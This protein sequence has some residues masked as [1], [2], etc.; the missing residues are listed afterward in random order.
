M[1]GGGGVDIPFWQPLSLFLIVGLLIFSSLLNLTRR[2][3][4]LTQP[5]VTKRV[6]SDTHLILK[7]QVGSIE[8]YPFL[9]FVW[10]FVFF[11]QK[12]VFFFFF[13]FDRA[14]I[15]D[16]WMGSSRCSPAL[17]LCHFTQDLF[18]F[19]FGYVCS[20]NYF[21]SLSNFKTL[22]GKKNHFWI[23]K[24]LKMWAWFYFA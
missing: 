24:L 9:F 13:F 23:V 3:R 5:W 20:V 4:S 10:F 1:G 18:L 11:S 8:G 15:I 22:G 16:C 12:V 21:N 19:S 14:S 6:Q 7:I 2:I 17:F